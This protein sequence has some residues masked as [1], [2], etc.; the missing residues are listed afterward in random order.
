MNWSNLPAHILEKI[1]DDA[2]DD[3]FHYDNPHAR[4]LNL[5]KLPLVGQMTKHKRDT[6]GAAGTNNRF[7]L[8][9]RTEGSSTFSDSVCRSDVDIDADF[10]D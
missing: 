7:L 2:A 9:K 3:G 6:S 1:L 10:S 4:M 8:K 5:E